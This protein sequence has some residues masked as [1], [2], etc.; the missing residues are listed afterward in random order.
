MFTAF[1]SARAASS[2]TARA[3][4]PD[5]PEANHS[6]RSPSLGRA[7]PMT[8]LEMIWMG[9]VL[10]GMVTGAG[11][12]LVG[13][14]LMDGAMAQIS[15]GNFATGVAVFCAGGFALKLLFERL[16]VYEEGRKIFMRDLRQQI[17]LLRQKLKAMDNTRSAAHPAMRA[18]RRTG[19]GEPSNRL[20]V[21]L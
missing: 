6:S 5:A 16:A 15:T 11:S 12:A 2:A 7:F 18:D 20:P 19:S 14:A 21:R 3:Q 9:G 17:C 4:A 1:K 8:Y 10:G 13:I